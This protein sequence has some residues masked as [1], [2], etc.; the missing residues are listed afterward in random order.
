MTFLESAIAGTKTLS[1]VHTVHNTV[2]RAAGIAATWTF[3]EYCIERMEQ[4]AVHNA[5]LA[6]A[7]P[8]N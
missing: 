5:P 7:N 3:E 1:Q 8:R 2:Q 4:T 6:S